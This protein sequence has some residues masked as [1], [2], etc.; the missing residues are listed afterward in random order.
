MK[1]VGFKPEEIE[2]I[3]KVVAGILH[4]GNVNFVGTDSVKV[5]NK[6]DL[7]CAAHAFDITD[8]A[9]EKAL[10]SRTVKDTSRGGKDI[11]TSING[12]QVSFFQFFFFFT[13]IQKNNFFF[14]KKKKANYSRDAL[15]KSTY[16]RLFSWVVSK[17]NDNIYSKESG[18]KAVIGVLDIYGFEILEV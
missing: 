13:K 1:A 9:L 17:I 10:I 3:F 7:D 6:A 14:F 5:S 16:D 4:L 18:A 8:G 2:G 11:T 15:A 12:D